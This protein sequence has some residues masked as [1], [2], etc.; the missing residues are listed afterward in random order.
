MLIEIGP[1]NLLMRASAAS[2]QGK[3]MGTQP[4]AQVEQVRIERL[5]G[6]AQRLEIMRRSLLRMALVGGI[7]LAYTLIVRASPS[8]LSVLMALGVA[9]FIGFLN[10]V[11]NGWLRRKQDVMRFHFTPCEG[12]RRFTAENAKGAEFFY[13]KDKLL[14]LGMGHAK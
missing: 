14:T 8:G 7:V 13:N 1:Q 12:V 6:K 5:S 3:I 4:L 2:A 9:A 10:F 11:L